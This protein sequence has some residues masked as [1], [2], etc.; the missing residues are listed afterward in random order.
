MKPEKTVPMA[1][2]DVLKFLIVVG[3]VDTRMECLHNEKRLTFFMAGLHNIQNRNELPF[4]EYDS[5]MGA[6]LHFWKQSK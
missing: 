1:R 4:P 6:L 3:C 5:I 2:K